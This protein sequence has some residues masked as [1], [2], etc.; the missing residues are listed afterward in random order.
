MRDDMFSPFN[1]CR[2]KYASEHFGK[3]VYQCNVVFDMKHLT[4][5]LDMEC[6]YYIKAILEIDQVG[7]C[8]S[9]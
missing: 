3:E 5:N 1:A 8:M 6:I 2:M 4:M 7:Y 9:C